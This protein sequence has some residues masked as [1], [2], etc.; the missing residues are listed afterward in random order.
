MTRR[1]ASTGLHG[2]S[3]ASEALWD[4][5]IADLRVVNQDQEVPEV[6][7]L[8]LV[9]VLRARDRLSEIA[10]K[11]QEQGLT[12]E[13]STGQLRPHPLLET[14]ARLRAEVRSG[15]ER[16]GLTGVGRTWQIHGGPGGR[17]QRVK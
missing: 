10:G 12:V 5:L 11:I 16:L 14:E 1:T 3:Q 15:L 13:G 17:L 6:D 7:E 9:D 4:G 2:L 8:L